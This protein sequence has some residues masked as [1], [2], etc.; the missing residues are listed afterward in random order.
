MREGH[1]QDDLQAAF[2]ALRE[3]TRP[4]GRGHGEGAAT[5]DRVL[6]TSRARA[7][8][9]LFALKVGMPIAAVLIVTSAWAAASGRLHRP[10]AE[11]G[12]SRSNGAATLPPS[13][14]VE[15][16]EKIATAS[17]SNQDSVAPQAMEVAS[18]EASAPPTR[19]RST[20]TP[21]MRPPVRAVTA[22]P[23]A[24]AAI[25]TSPVAPVPN[26]LAEDKQA[27]ESAYRIHASGAPAAA[28][29][30]WDGY[31][32]AHPDGRFV[33]EARYARAVALARNGQKDAARDALREFANG[34][35]RHDDA[36]KLLD[37]LQ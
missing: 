4:S 27:F 2:V 19:E 34:E 13:Q 12:G 20:P 1:V 10:H 36:I 17:P 26:L 5:L 21:V 16:I 32:A 23:P 8:R 30:A 37:K 25:A 6:R 18:P 7:K 3:E 14:L 33:P 9:R 29:A 15:R 11:T 35:Y 28:V 22:L 24:S 31:L